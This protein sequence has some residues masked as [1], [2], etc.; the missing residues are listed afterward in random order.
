MNDKKILVQTKTINKYLSTDNPFVKQAVGK[1]ASAVQAAATHAIQTVQQDRENISDT[2]DYL[3]GVLTDQ[4][5]V[6]LVE[7]IQDISSLGQEL[8]DFFDKTVF[9]QA[10]PDSFEEI[11]DKLEQ[12]RI[13]EE[14]LQ[15]KEAELEAIIKEKVAEAEKKVKLSATTSKGLF[16]SALQKA[17]KVIDQNK[18]TRFV[19]STISRFQDEFEQLQ[20]TRDVEHVTKIFQDTIEPFQL[21]K[22]VADKEGKLTKIIINS[23][24]EDCYQDLFFFFYRYYNELMDI[25]EGE[26]ELPSTAEELA[27]IFKKKKKGAEQ[28]IAQ[29]HARK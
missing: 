18:I 9:R 25:Y 11:E 22:V 28:I 2:T 29:M 13:R 23:F 17:D 19:C 5:G 15:N 12:V 27:R 16:E 1:I 14:I 26:G 4:L 20:K 3:D 7:E 21:T 6:S 24:T 8:E 10:F